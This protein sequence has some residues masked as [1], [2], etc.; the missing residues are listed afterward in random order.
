[1]RIAAKGAGTPATSGIPVLLIACAIA[2]LTPTLSAR[3]A[4]SAAPPSADH[5]NSAPVWPTRFE[6]KPLRSL[7]LGERERRFA[8]DFPGHI[9]RFTDGEREIVMRWVSRETRMLHPASDCFRGM[10]YTL[11]PRPLSVDSTG[12]R[13]GA[14]IARHGN[15]RLDVRERLY[16]DAGNEWTDVSAWYWAATTGTSR[17]PWW[18]ITTAQVAIESAA[19]QH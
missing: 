15:Q 10:G 19:L 5:Q 16:D 2:A 12:A 18:A 13:W 17:G 8:A 14:F 1:M 6:G 4:L 3:H 7:P 11:T 9:A